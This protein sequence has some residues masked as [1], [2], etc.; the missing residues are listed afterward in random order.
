MIR[1]RINNNATPCN[2]TQT[3]RRALDSVD[4]ETDLRVHTEELGI[5]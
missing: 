3:E 4:G 1:G 5:R 2:T